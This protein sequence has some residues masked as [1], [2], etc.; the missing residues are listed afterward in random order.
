MEQ[1]DRLA[2]L[3]LCD[4]ILHQKEQ[5]KIHEFGMN[6]GLNPEDVKRILQFM[7]LAP[8]TIIDSNLLFGIFR[9]N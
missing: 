6:M 1:F 7:E 5:I 8:N 4:G 2:F 9:N 3:L